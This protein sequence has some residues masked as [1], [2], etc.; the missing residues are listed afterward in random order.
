MITKDVFEL[1]SN[2]MIIALP[3]PVMIESQLP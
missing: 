2:V 3:I 1:S